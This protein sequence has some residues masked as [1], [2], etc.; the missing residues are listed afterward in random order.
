MSDFKLSFKNDN[1]DSHLC[2]EYLTDF[3]N[4]GLE[5]SKRLFF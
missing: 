4:G 2:L 3:F 5:V 1:K